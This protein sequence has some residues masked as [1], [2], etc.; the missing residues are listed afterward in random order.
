MIQI[1]IVGIGAS[2]GGLKEFEQFFKNMPCS[3]ELAFVIV[4]HLSPNYKSTLADIVNR[5]TEMDVC[6]IEDNIE[7]QAGKVYIIPP[8]KQLRLDK[9]RLMLHEME[10]QHGLNLP[11]DVFFRSLKENLGK[12][13]IAVILSGTGSDGASGIKEI[14][15]SGGLTIIQQ[16]ETA[17][18]DDMPRNAIHTGL[19]DYVIQVKDM[20]NV[21]LAYIE[22]NF[23]DVKFITDNKKSESLINKLFEK[24]L[25]QTGHDF[26]NYKRNSIYRRIERRITVNKFNDLKEYVDFIINNKEETAI[27]Y[28]VLLISVTSFFRDKEVFEYIQ[29]KLIPEIVANAEDKNLRIWIPACA[30]GEEAYS[31]AIIF[32]N[33]ITDHKLN[34]NLQIFASDID[35]DAIDKAREGYY[36]N[37]I[38]ADVPAEIIKRN[39]QKENNGFRIDK[40]IRESVI[41]AEQNLI[42]DPPYSRLDLISCRNLLIY[43]DNYL[44]NKAIS[45][46][47]YALK[48]S[49][50]LVL[51]YSESLGS[52][53]QFYD[54]IDRKYKLYRKVN[55]IEM[56]AKL[57]KV[58]NFR[59][60]NKQIEKKQ[61]QEPISEIAKEFILETQTPPCVVID[62]EGTMLYA[63]GKT[64]KFLEITTGEI[65]NNILKTAK[66]GLK[67]PLSNALRKA[68]KNNSEVCLH[69][70]KFAPKDDFEYIDIVVTPLKNKQKDTKLFVVVYKPGK[71]IS[72]NKPEEDESNS[73]IVT[74]YEL[75]KELAEKEQYLQNTIEELETTNEELKSSNEE[76]QSTNE[77]LQSANEELETS[78]EELQ[79]VN[80]ELTTTNNELGIKV[81]ELDKVNS[82]LKN[83]FVATEIGTIFLDKDLRIFNFTPSISIIIG[84]IKS[85]IGRPIEQFTYNLKY[86]HLIEDAKEVLKTLIPKEAKVEN[87]D[88]KN[89]WMRILPYRTTDDKIEGVV[90]TFTD[91]TEHVRIEQALKNSEEKYRTTYEKAPDS[92]II[93]DFEMNIIDVN[94]KAVQEFGYSKEEFMLLKVF[95]LHSKD[96]LKHLEKVL[97]EMGKKDMLT[98]DTKFLRKDGSLFWAS[99]TPCKYDLNGKT[100][101]HVVIRNITDLV[102]SRKELDKHRNHLE[103]LIVEKSQKLVESEEKFKTIF[104]RALS[105]ITVTDDNGNYLSANK[106]ASDL[107]GYSIDEMLKMNVLDLKALKK[108]E[109]EGQ[110]EIYQGC[111]DE[112]G[113]IEFQNKEGIRK[114]AIFKAIRVKKDFNL[115]M[116]FDITDKVNYEKEL[117]TKADELDRLD[118][119]KNDFISVLAH[120]LKNPLNGLVGFSELLLESIDDADKKT[121]KKQIGII[122]NSAKKTYKLLNDTLLWANPSKY[123]LDSKPAYVN[124]FKLIDDEVS[125]NSPQAEKKCIKIKNEAEFD[126]DI[127]INEAILTVVLRN[128]L[129]N[130]I[131][132]TPENGLITINAEQTENELIIHISDTGVGIAQTDI[133]ELFAIKHIRTT[134]GTNKEKGTGF[135]LKI[136]HKLLRSI[137]GDITVKSTKGKGSSFSF[138]LPINDVSANENNTGIQKSNSSKK[139]LILVTDD[140]EINY[141]LLL[142]LIKESI[143]LDCDI[144]YAANGLEAVDLCLAENVDVV[145]MDIKMPVMDGIQAA[146]IIRETKTKLPIIFQSANLEG[147]YTRIVETW[148]NVDFLPK[149]IQVQDLDV[150]LSKM[151]KLKKD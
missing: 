30:T 61:M 51:G 94:Q 116:L 147:N 85:D 42:Q 57:W 33:Y 128:L 96:E 58:S 150:I 20:P 107:L 86:S 34:I 23:Q 148:G 16:P 143:K 144:L 111:K 9:N 93:H 79:S 10:K 40:S 39:F 52:S 50:C 133:D 135:G 95:D 129:S 119:D 29:E 137:G 113:E 31:W 134:E 138:S 108:P 46:F 69:N 8:N 80:E 55:D 6:Q 59:Q 91:I 118:K 19:I 66:S 106:A 88:N 76:S 102:E 124:I 17:D 5:Y 60:S 47:N 145:L 105:P 32:K 56:S 70:I 48:P 77:E 3:K 141:E 45:I 11:I 121:L 100:I 35:T 139:P 120:D 117:V 109:A 49:G 63:Q 65:S 73:E 130:A 103:E 81:D 132:F 90:I 21:I 64:G 26:S 7:I 87:K 1:P 67:V 110:S 104:E 114:T 15:E 142:L 97:E 13:A 4:Q 112:S 28:K 99:V 146:K 126:S 149:P 37:N 83:L 12:R 82:Q 92:I 71:S 68:R 151:L 89:F 43:L 122:N 74:I 140:E 53:A 62:P 72:I 78:K 54:V 127:F 136:C 115:S 98:A 2:A 44:Q 36:N 131:K 125:T 25:T 38:I 14:K 18:Y 84:L 22:N 75:E 101:I 24:I 27:L 41:F 123:T